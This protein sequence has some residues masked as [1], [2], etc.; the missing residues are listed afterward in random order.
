METPGYFSLSV[1]RPSV[2]RYLRSVGLRLLLPATVSMMWTPISS[3]LI[4]GK[5]SRYAAK[6]TVPNT[7]SEASPVLPSGRV[8]TTGSSLT[9]R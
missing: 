6:A 5:L 3:L 7:L 4:P 2:T 1:F 9:A 8:K